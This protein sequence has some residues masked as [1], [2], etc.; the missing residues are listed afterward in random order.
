VFTIP[1]ARLVDRLIT[2]Q[3]TRYQRGTGLA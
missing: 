3:Q 2:V 1:L